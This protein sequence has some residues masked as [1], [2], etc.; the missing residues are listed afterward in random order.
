MGKRSE[1]TWGPNDLRRAF[2]EGAAWWELHST[3]FTMWQ[4]DRTVAED[5]AGRRYSD[6]QPAPPE[7]TAKCIANVG[8]DCDTCPRDMQYCG[9][10]RTAEPTKEDGMEIEDIEYMQQNVPCE[11]CGCFGN[12]S[13]GHEPVDKEMCCTLDSH[14]V[15]ACCNS[16]AITDAAE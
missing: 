3:G 8:S 11:E 6:Q 5:E 9:H 10:Y 15:C 1:G 12:A 13:C 2:V 4:S 7:L 14:M 16:K